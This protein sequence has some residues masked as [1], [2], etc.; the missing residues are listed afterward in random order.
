MRIAG[1]MGIGLT[2]TRRMVLLKRD[3]RRA[4]PVLSLL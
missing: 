3:L 1:G 4:C 2:D